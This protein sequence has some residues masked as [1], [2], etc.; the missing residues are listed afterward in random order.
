MTIKDYM[1]DGDQVA[2]EQIRSEYNYLLGQKF[3]LM[4]QR[5]SLLQCRRSV[6]EVTGRIGAMTG[7]MKYLDERANTLSMI[8]DVTYVRGANPKHTRIA[9]VWTE[10]DF[11]AMK[12]Q[13]VFEK[14]SKRRGI[15]HKGPYKKRTSAIPFIDLYAL[16]EESQ[17]LINQ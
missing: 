1:N 5:D 10:E 3:E 2:L 4:A 7:R 14:P 6:A 8:P 9:K 13:A 11:E 16:K 17:H 12:E 15:P